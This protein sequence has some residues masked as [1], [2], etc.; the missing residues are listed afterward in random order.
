MGV[1]TAALASMLGKEATSASAPLGG[2]SN[3]PNYP[4]KA[5]R[6]IYLMQTGAP[7][8]VDLLDYKPL[9]FQKHGENI[10]DSVRE[11][12]RLSTMTAGYDNYPT[13]AP[14]AQFHRGPSGT[15][16]SDLLPY[17]REISDKICVVNSMHTEAVNHAP[18][19]TFFLTG[20]QLPGRPSM[21]AWL[22]YGLGSANE[23]L[24]NFM[25]MTSV[26]RQ[27]SCGQLFYDYYWGSGF[28][29]TKHQG[30]KFRG[31]GDPVLYLSDP[32]GVSRKMKKGMID[33]IAALNTEHYNEVADP[34]IQTRIAQYEMAYRM[35][36]SVPDLTDIS[37]EPQHILDMYGP[38]VHRP[39]SFARNCLM[40]RRMAERGV[41]YVQLMH[42]GWDQHNNIPTQLAIQCKDTDQ[43][44]AAL[45]KDLEQRGLLDD[46]LVVWGGEFGRT[47][48][49]QGDITNPLKHGRDHHGAAFS[50]WMAGAGVQPGMQYGKT[51]E[52][53]Y[54]V[55]ENKVHI[56]D[57]QATLLHLMGIDHEQLTFRFQG[58]RFRLTDVH[59]HV[60]KDI[61]G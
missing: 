25:V 37:D 50:L 56:H 39:G 53:G 19:V 32:D 36:T 8:H 60:V 26:D 40:A 47:P 48:F 59:G 14:Q 28:I 23:D 3:F 6:I 38:D 35:Q 21:G 18:A 4:G 58:R 22:S 30:V 57:F 16:I 31:T 27:N 1:G 9:T 34:E 24:P 13:L 41:Q 17:T 52:Y 51:D 42:A 5:K 10:P 12:V 33:D 20:H 15:M 61:L 7:S 29:P 54:N 55:V 49:G 11:G 44:S 2:L 45:V 43:P 46:T